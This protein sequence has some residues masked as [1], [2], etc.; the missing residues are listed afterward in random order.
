M[1]KI[2]GLGHVGIYAEDLMGQRDF[3]TRVLGLKSPT[4]I[5][6]GGG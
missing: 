4:R 6:T 5:W 2:E 1:A 3:Y